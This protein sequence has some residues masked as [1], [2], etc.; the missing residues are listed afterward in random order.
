[1]SAGSLNRSTPDTAPTTLPRERSPSTAPLLLWLL[2]QLGAILLAVLR[3]PL[4][5]A[6]R[7]PAEQ[8]APYLLFAVQVVAAGMLFPFLLRDWRTAVQVI[9]T[10]IPFQLAAVYLAGLEPRAM[11]P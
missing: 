6:Y 11:L 8:L 2:I 1:M 10:A 4:A 3:V 9:A 7:E 5:A